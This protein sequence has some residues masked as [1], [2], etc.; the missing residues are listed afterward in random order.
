[1]LVLH[2]IKYVIII[3]ETE[4]VVKLTLIEVSDMSK[5]QLLR[6]NFRV[7]QFQEI[8]I[9]I[10]YVI[11][12]IILIIKNIIIENRFLIKILMKALI[13]EV[14]TNEIFYNFFEGKK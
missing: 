9:K 1:M 11:I 6:R 10:R 4:H 14:T 13:H 8:F 2:N 12:N 7:N 3:Q 5:Y